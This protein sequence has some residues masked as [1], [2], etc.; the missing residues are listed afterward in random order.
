MTA[1]AVEGVHGSMN[2][3]LCLLVC[4]VMLIG[5]GGCSVWNPITQLMDS[6]EKKAAET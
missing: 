6:P 2:R 4:C 1:E 3:R 5:L